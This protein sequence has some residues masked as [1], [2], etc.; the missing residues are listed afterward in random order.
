MFGVNMNT[1]HARIKHK[2]IVRL[3][4]KKLLYNLYIK[5]SMGI[6]AISKKFDVCCDTIKKYLL[7]HDIKLRIKTD[8]SKIFTEKYLI[9][10][11][12]QNKKSSKIIAWENKSDSTNVVRYLHLYNI[13]IRSASESRKLFCLN[14]PNVSSSEN[15]G[16]FGRTGKSNPAYKNGIP[17]CLDCGKKLGD[18]YSI[19]CKP[20]DGINKTVH[21]MGYLPYT[22]EFI[23]IRGQILIRDSLICQRCN[24][25]NEEHL[26]LYSRR[27]EVHHIDYNKENCKPTNL[28]VLCKRCNIKANFDR[29]YWFAY[30]TY[31]MENYIK[32]I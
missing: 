13:Q 4:T 17:N 2:T 25:S 26:F 6:F 27:I 21:G 3:L 10:E 7:I 32:E 28:I 23:N 1:I 29:D 11:Y 31:I 30:Y 18:Y 16:M 15:N 14:N 19:R 24:M 12:L 8:W 22:S 9:T 20:C 5:Q